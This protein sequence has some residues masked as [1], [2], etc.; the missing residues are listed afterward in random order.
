MCGEK[1]VEKISL[2]VFWLLTLR[3]DHWYILSSNFFEFHKIVLFKI[4]KKKEIIKV[5]RI[6]IST[7]HRS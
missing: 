4:K 6:F 5:Y 2:T 7:L 3:L 1:L